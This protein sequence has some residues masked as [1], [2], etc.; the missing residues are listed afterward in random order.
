MYNL[1]TELGGGDIDG[2]SEHGIR[3]LICQPLNMI[4]AM[5]SIVCQQG[6]MYTSWFHSPTTSMLVTARSSTKMKTGFQ[7]FL[8]GHGQGLGVNSNPSWNSAHYWLFWNVLK[9]VYWANA[10]LCEVYPTCVSSKLC[11]FNLI[12][13]ITIEE[14]LA[15]CWLVDGSNFIVHLEKTLRLTGGIR[16]LHEYVFTVHPLSSFDLW[17]IDT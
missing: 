17:Y 6:L 3:G 7:H 16:H 13:I 11:E 5:I 14:C 15:C 9:Q 12:I 1:I 4:R 2:L 10:G 8:H